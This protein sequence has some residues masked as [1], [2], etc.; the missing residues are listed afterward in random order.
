MILLPF[1][2]SALLA[3]TTPQLHG[4]W[5]LSAMIYR[6]NEV[7]PLNPNLNLR[8]S[9]FENGTE[10]LYWD[11]SDED[12]FCER[13][14]NYEVSDGKLWE[15]VYAV[16]PMNNSTCNQDPDM[17]VG[18]ETVTKIEIISQKILLHLSLGDEELIYVLKEVL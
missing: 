13:F 6:G 16:N 15:K 7:P 14:A 12:G 4:E 17:H 3:Q 2:F 10:R 11:R 8:W 18:R 9:F 1:Y 5:R